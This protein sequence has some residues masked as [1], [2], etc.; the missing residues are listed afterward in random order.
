NVPASA[1]VLP[2]GRPPSLTT[3]ALSLSARAG[4]PGRVL[5][6]RIDRLRVMGLASGRRGWR[7][8]RGSLDEAFA[9]NRHEFFRRMWQDA[10]QSVGA[11]IEDLGDGF[12]VLRRGMAETL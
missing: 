1:S 7:A 2:T 8:T 3:R 11:D 12:R 6:H 9:R 5:S 4:T 10:A